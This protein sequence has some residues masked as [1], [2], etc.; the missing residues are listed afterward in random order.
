MPI[1]WR[2]SIP[3]RDS[4][5]LGPSTQYA[6]M[7][8]NILS[9]WLVYVPYI[10]LCLTLIVFSYTYLPAIS[11]IRTNWNT[12]E[13]IAPLLFQWLGLDNLSEWDFFLNLILVC[14]INGN[15]LRFIEKKNYK[16]WFGHFLVGHWP[17]DLKEEP[18]LMR[19]Y[20]DTIKQLYLYWIHANEGAKRRRR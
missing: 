15:N 2:R 11:A 10:G 9:V 4:S 14:N 20:F 19:T 17:I 5:S 18:R 3:D 16:V 12:A 13:L 6:Y 7:G 1:L 8:Q